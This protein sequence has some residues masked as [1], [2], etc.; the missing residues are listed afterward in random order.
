M[1]SNF[2]KAVLLITRELLIVEKSQRYCLKYCCCGNLLS[3]KAF[4]IKV[5]FNHEKSDKC[6]A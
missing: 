3:S 4:E 5:G 2:E 6:F 1:C